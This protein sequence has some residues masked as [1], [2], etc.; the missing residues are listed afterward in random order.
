MRQSLWENS[1]ASRSRWSRLRC[2]AGYQ[3]AAC[4]QQACFSVGKSRLVGGCGPM[5]RPT[6]L[7][8]GVDTW[9][10]T[11]EKLPATGSSG[12]LEP[13]HRERPRHDLPGFFQVLYHARSHRLNQDVADCRCFHW[14][15]ND[16]STR[17]V[18]CQL[19]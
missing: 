5:A 11:N 16:D 17:D 18:G 14:S 9:G 6:L 3:P 15:G 2:G 12:R 8:A 4:Y 10:S 13:L 7:Q 1:R 19:V